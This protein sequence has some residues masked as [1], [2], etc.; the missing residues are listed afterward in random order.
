MSASYL[1]SFEQGAPRKTAQ[2]SKNEVLPTTTKGAC[3]RSAVAGHQA[4]EPEKPG[5]LRQARQSR[6]RL[7]GVSTGG[8]CH[9]R[10]SEPL[11]GRATACVLRHPDGKK[12]DRS[13]SARVRPEKCEAVF[14]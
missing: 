11:A 1:K 9:P 12:A 5:A 7:I 2:A 6:M 10:F 13:L 8:R 3:G 4:Q 14:R